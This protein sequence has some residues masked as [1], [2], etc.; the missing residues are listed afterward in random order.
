MAGLK[1]LTVAYPRADFWLDWVASLIMVST[2]WTWLHTVLREQ[3]EK[4]T[5]GMIGDVFSVFSVALDRMLERRADKTGW[6]RMD[7][8]VE[9]W[10]LVAV[11][12]VPLSIAWLLHHLTRIVTSVLVGP[13]GS[14]LFVISFLLWNFAKLLTLAKG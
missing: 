13:A 8:T 5:G 6:R 3:M 1:S 7:R 4:A 11:M 2:V 10:L 12:S 14:V 9:M